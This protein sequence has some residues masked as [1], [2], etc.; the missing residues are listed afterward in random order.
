MDIL[1]NRLRQGQKMYA[2]SKGFMELQRVEHQEIGKGAN[3]GG[4]VDDINNTTNI[5]EEWCESNERN[6][7]RVR[8][9]VSKNGEVYLN[10]GEGD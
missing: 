5:R 2:G 3:K 7:I 10:K 8:E 6:V 4:W 1:C 9:M